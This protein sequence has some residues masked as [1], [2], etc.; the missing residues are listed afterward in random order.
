MEC[1]KISVNHEDIIE[2]IDQ[3]RSKKKQRQDIKVFFNYLMR[4]R[5]WKMSHYLIR[6]SKTRNDYVWKRNKSCKQK[7]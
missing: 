5:I 6:F 4:W 2:A 3:I 1:T 7:I